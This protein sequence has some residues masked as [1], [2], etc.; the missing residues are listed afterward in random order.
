MTQKALILNE[1]GTPLVLTDR[2]IPVPGEDELPIKVT[3][4]GR[5]YSPSLHRKRTKLTKQ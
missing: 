1:I 3:S 4:A 2:P 5:E